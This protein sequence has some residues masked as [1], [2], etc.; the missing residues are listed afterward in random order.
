MKHYMTATTVV[1]SLLAMLNVIP[2]AHAAPPEWTTAASTCVPDES[3]EGNA[4]YLTVI[5]DRANALATPRIMRVRLF[6]CQEG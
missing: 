6:H 4:Y 3:S 5:L 1:A 2:T